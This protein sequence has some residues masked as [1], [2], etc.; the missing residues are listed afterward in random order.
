MLGA[1]NKILLNDLI[2]KS[3][4]LY[5]LFSR[6]QEYEADQR[7]CNDGVLTQRNGKLLKAY[8]TIC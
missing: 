4:S 5:L 2:N 1:V 7:E 3:A 6:S 8:G